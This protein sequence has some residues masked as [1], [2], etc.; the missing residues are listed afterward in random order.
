MPKIPIYPLAFFLFC[1]LS[2]FGL[3]Y[4][5]IIFYSLDYEY[6]VRNYQSFF[7]GLCYQIEVSA[8]FS[9]LSLFVS[10]FSLKIQ[11]IYM[12]LLAAVYFF[13]FYIDLRYLLQ[14]NTHFPVSI[15]QYLKTGEVYQ[16]FWVEL[17]RLEFLFFACSPI[18]FLFF[19]YSFFP[20]KGR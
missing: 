2:L 6:S 9:I 7:I 8:I 4:Q 15:L 14:F 5:T 11:K 1:S 12:L 13:I 10:Y 3:Y 18:Y 17:W 20:F 16:S 19:C